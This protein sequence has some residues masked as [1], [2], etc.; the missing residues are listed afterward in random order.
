MCPQRLIK[1]K[2]FHFQISTFEAKPLASIGAL[3]PPKPAPDQTEERHSNVYLALEATPRDAG[4]LPKRTEL[5]ALHSATL[6]ASL[7]PF[8]RSQAAPSHAA[9]YQKNP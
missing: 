7:T 5:E 4:L 6:P 2:W 3:P 9:Q 1:T 8:S